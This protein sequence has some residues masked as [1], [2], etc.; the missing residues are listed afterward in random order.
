MLIMVSFQKQY[1]KDIA[2]FK[3][4]GAAG[5]MGAGLMAFTNT[6]LKSGID[7][8]LD[9]IGIDAHLKD[10]DIVFVGEGQLDKQTAMGK[11]PMGIAQ[12][13]KKHGIPVIAIGGSVDR[14]PVELHD[15]GITAYFSAVGRPMSLEQAMSPE[16]TRAGLKRQGRELVQLI[17]L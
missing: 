9:Q 11:A 6:V 2:N 17:K 13:A 1:N 5:G 14:D 10:A 15:A 4:S 3:G 16:E 12:R 8:I 7:I